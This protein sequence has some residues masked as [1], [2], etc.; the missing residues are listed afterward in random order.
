MRPAPLLGA[1]ACVL[2]LTAVPSASQAAEPP[3]QDDPCSRGGRN[4]CGTLGVGFYKEYRYGI[5]WFGSF[6]GAIPDEPAT[7]CIDLR[8]WY[9]SRAHGFREIP[10]GPGL[11]NRDDELVAVHNQRKLAY[12]VWNYGR[13]RDRNQAAAVMLYV[14]SLMGDGRPGELD[15]AA[16]GPAVVA[17]YERI[18]RDARRYH[19]P[20]RI[21][22]RV[23]AGLRVGRP[24]T[25]ALRLLSAAGNPVPNARI[26][27]S[28]RGGLREEAS[29]DARGSVRVGFTPTTVGALRLA[30]RTGP[31]A[32][33]LP[34]LFRGSAPA[35][36]RNGQRLAVPSSQV[37]T[38]ELTAPVAKARLAVSTVAVP[39]RLLVGEESRDRITVQGALPSWR[40]TIAVRVY[41]PFPSL[42]AIRCDGAPAWRGSFRA[43]GSGVFM[44]PPAALPA[45]GWYG[46]QEDI[47][48]D[49]NHVGLTTPC[50]EPLETFRVDTQP[51][52]R[53]IV[54]AAR[55][56]PGARL[57]DRVFVE[58]LAGQ[59]ATVRAA[60]YGPY[61]S[62]EAMDCAGRPVWE[63]TIDVRA[64]GEYA[65]EPT[66]V[67]APGFYTYREWIAS[68]G[69]VRAT[70]T[71]C[72]EAT[73]TT[74]AVAQPKIRTRVSAQEA[75]PG[76]HITDRVV[77]TGLGALAARVR[78]V[79]WGPF[80]RRDRIRCTGTPY[81]TGSFV[82]RG[83]GTY[84]TTPVRLG[85]AG[86][87]TYQETIAAGPLTTAYTTPCGEVVE[88]TV[89]RAAPA[90]ST[91]AS[92]EVVFP[93]SAI[94]DTIRVTGLGETPAAIDVELFGPFASRDDMRCDGRPFWRGRVYARGDG[95]LRSP[96]VR[97]PRA[98]F[99]TFRERVAATPLV[100]EHETAC[101]LAAETS[102]ARPLILTGR[103]D[104]PAAAAAPP[105]AGL[106]PARVQLP[107]ASIDARVTPVAIDLAAGALG[108]PPDIRRTGWWR[109]GMTPG[110]A[111]GSIL[112]TGH[113]D[114]ARGGAGAFYRLK[115]AKVGD[116][117][118]VTTRNGRGF[119]YRVTSIRSYPKHQLP[120]ELYSRRGPRRL[121][122][123]TCGGAFD[124]TA[125]RY[126]DNVVV[127]AVPL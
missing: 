10:S 25:V 122:L 121:V 74:V 4:V 48:G 97:V 119:V 21:A 12:A 35:A 84:T 96:R 58:G 32:S 26:L 3:N 33:T 94:F 124:R 13:T 73:E 16:L 80:S 8:F 46:Y 109:D 36:A 1:V 15:P 11:R 67:R 20:Y 51:R 115:D 123:V 19:G 28:G 88:T 18:A 63:G 37:V 9:P 69:F 107:A 45:V 126:R 5:R 118:R 38:A 52:V 72:G 102:L 54:S 82:A 30:V 75:H 99:Y 87:Y 56:T 68:R 112:I 22:A 101:G 39:S 93:G 117:V 31:L 116:R 125:R 105:A 6:R 103:G 90:V 98:G 91:V 47:P 89:A 127:T 23:S 34:K 66:R 43:A 78:V 14:H 40:G 17:R 108:V 65:T 7:Y 44:S 81:W 42:A 92:A 85:R 70:E 2:A 61:P 71:A 64:D 50:R 59:L 114:S 113:V 53:T 104:T 100:R 77:V 95:I 110:A 41:G 111:E 62:R 76:A 29:T 57:H 106:T 86:Y 60:L 120:A 83:D 49:A 79:L 55:V 24:G 27:V